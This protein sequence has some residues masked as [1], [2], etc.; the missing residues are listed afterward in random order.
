M[1]EEAAREM[2]RE[3]IEYES[4][5]GLVREGRYGGGERLELAYDLRARPVRA[6]FEVLDPVSNTTYTTA[7]AGQ[8][9]DI[10][11]AVAAA[12]EA[13]VNGPWPRMKA[14]ERARVLNRIADAVEALHA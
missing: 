12:R 1:P 4:A 13:F 14:R 8:K 10:D 3:E 11:A 7:A 2:S 9:E 6:T 5:T